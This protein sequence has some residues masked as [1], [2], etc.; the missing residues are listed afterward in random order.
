MIQKIKKI[1]L[2]LSSL[3]VFS[4]P[5]VA[6]GGVAVAAPTVEECLAQGARLDLETATCTKDTANVG[7]K[8]LTDFI[9]SALNVLS[10]VVGVAA[11]VMI[12][13]GGFRY[14]ASGGKQ[15]SVTSAKNNILYAL[16]G[17]IIVALAQ[18]IVRFVLNKTL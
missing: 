18:V 9:A 7:G 12:I 8:R 4:V 15:E 17:L 5:L 14:I 3:F 13:V 11:V 10:I 1:V 6:T 2:T 16:I